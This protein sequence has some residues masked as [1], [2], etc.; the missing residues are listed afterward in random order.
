[1]DSDGRISLGSAQ[2]IDLDLAVKADSVEIYTYN[3]GKLKEIG[4]L[5][6][7]GKDMVSRIYKDDELAKFDVGPDNGFGVVLFPDVI[8]FHSSEEFFEYYG[9]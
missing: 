8:L 5:D 2:Y 3:Q 7:L 6:E 4:T 1:M 9:Y